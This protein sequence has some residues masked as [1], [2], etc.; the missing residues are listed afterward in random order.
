MDDKSRPCIKDIEYMLLDGKQYGDR[1]YICAKYTQLKIGLQFYFKMG[2]DTADHIIKDFTQCNPSTEYVFQKGN[3]YRDYVCK[4]KTQCYADSLKSM[5]E[6]K[7]A[8]DSTSSAVNG[9][10]AVCANFSTCKDGYEVKVPG[11]DVSD[12]QCGPCIPGT[13]L[14]ASM[15]MFQVHPIVRVLCV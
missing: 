10:D 8:V 14:D 5:Y 9:T 4:R 15:K 11:T 1:D 3:L 13:F 12:V 2:T 7:A 6:M